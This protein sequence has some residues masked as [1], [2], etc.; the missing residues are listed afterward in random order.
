[1]AFACIFDLEI[2]NYAR[3]ISFTR[4]E[5]SKESENVQCFGLQNATWLEL[6]DVMPMMA[7][8][9]DHRVNVNIQCQ[10]ERVR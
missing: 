5:D 8:P 9:M 1:M 4:A 2:S 6:N 7:H 3:P 10:R